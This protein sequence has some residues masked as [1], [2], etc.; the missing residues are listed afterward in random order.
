VADCVLS[1]VAQWA[2]SGALADLKSRNANLTI[3]SR[4]ASF[5]MVVLQVMPYRSTDLHL[6][7][8]RPWMQDL[9]NRQMLFW[10]ERAPD[11]AKRG[12]LR[13]WAALAGSAT[14]TILEDPIIRGWS[15]GS[16]SY[17]VCTAESD[18]ALPQEM[19]RGKYAL[20]YQLHA[21]A[22]LTVSTALLAR[23]G[24]DLTSICGGALDRV[25]NFAVSDLQTGQRTATI[26]GKTQS[27]FDGTDKIEGFNLAWLEA[28][29]SVH[30]DPALTT[31][32]DQYRPL[33]YSKLGGNQTLMWSGF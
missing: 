9:M 8:I 3:G 1:Q 11:G 29:L 12:N 5:G 19:T 4:L 13:A 30:Y 14:S 31:L 10:E 15:A 26:T 17:V 27:F 18:G 21:I 32:A 23:K 2:G 6:V 25:V 22:P 28:Y 16:A 33:N 24:I 20:H 7:T